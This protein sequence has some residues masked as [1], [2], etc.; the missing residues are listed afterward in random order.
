[1][2][3]SRRVAVGNAMKTA[4]RGQ[5]E[6][7]HQLNCNLVDEPGC[8]ASCAKAANRHSTRFFQGF[9]VSARVFIDR[10]GVRWTVREAAAPAAPVE[11]RER[12]MQARSER[13][14]AHRTNRLSTRPLSLATLV[15]E[16]TTERRR[17]SPAPAGWV[18]LADAEL[19]DLLHRTTLE[20]LG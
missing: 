19:E 9:R 1:M 13:K 12:R 4:E 18:A 8:H 6:A 14:P 7:A 16:C 3:G 11:N 5:R 20:P 17:L 10:T 15:F 2:N